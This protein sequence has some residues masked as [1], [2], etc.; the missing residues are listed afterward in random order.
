MLPQL[1]LLGAVVDAAAMRCYIPEKIIGKLNR[2]ARACFAAAIAAASGFVDG[3]GA[4]GDVTASSADGDSFM[5]RLYALAAVAEAERAA[6][7]S[8]AQR[9]C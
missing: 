1:T 5:R 8:A 7:P 2:A 4:H 3:N 6:A 9:A